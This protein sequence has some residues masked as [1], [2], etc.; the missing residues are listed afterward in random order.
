MKMIKNVIFDVDGVLRTLLD[1]KICEHLSKN[2]K[3][4]YGS[5]YADLSMKDFYKKYCKHSYKPYVD[6]D[7]GYLS[8]TELSA[9]VEKDFGEPAE[10]FEEIFA[11]RRK[12]NSQVYFEES[13]E[14]AKKLKANGH[15]LF[16]LSNMGKELA[17]Q[18]IQK[19]SFLGF[20]DMVFS[21]YA[22]IMKPNPQL[23]NFAIEKWNIDPKE[24]IFIDD[25]EENLKPFENLGGHT[26]LFDSKN[27]K[28]SAN[29][30]EKIIMK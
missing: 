9:C 1:A 27:I 18:L 15:K 19:L 23:Y 17:D 13:F 21:C 11:Y 5:H 4:K 26:F 20:D 6:Y 12:P 24:S 29:T 2:N 16:V 25:R 28:E 8:E 30:L 10:I 22:H 7:N 14:L 3:E